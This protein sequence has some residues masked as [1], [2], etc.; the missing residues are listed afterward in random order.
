M[1]GNAKKLA[2]LVMIVA[3]A[4]VLPVAMVSA[5]DHAGKKFI[6][7]TYAVTGMNGVLLAPFGF[8]P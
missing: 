1:N 8:D 6:Q 4:I 3:L 5:D 7:G 2:V